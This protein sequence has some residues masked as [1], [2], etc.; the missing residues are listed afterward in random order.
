MRARLSGWTTVLILLGASSAWAGN[1]R[2]LQLGTLPVT[3]QGLRPTVRVGINGRRATFLLDSGAFYSTISAD[4]AARYRLALHAIPGDEVYLTGAG[5]GMTRPRLTTVK[6]FSYLSAPLHHVQF[7]VTPQNFWGRLAGSLGQNLLRVSDVEYDLAD[8]VVRF[9]RPVGC[10]GQPLAYWAE[11]TPYSVVKLRYLGVA[12]S[13]LLAHA[14]VNG[15]RITVLLDTGSPRSILSLQAARRA[16]ITRHSPG[17]KPLETSLGLGGLHFQVWSAPVAEFQIGGE[18]I[19]HTHL[20]IGNI[21]PRGPAGQIRSNRHVDM[22]LGADFF[23]SQRLYVAYSQHR[24]YFTYNGGPLFNLNLPQYGRAAAQSVAAAARPLGAADLMRRGMALA[25]LREFHRAIADLSRACTLA[26]HDARD[27]YERGEVYLAQQRYRAALADFDAA[28]HLAP[29]DVAAH[30]AR[31]ELR[32]GQPDAAAHRAQID[33]DLAAVA[34]QAAH[35]AALQLELGIL[36]GEAGRYRAGLAQINRWLATH[37]PRSEQATGLNARCWLRALSDR[38]LHRALADCNEALNLSAEDTTGDGPELPYLRP[39]LPGSDPAVRD[40][41]AL[42]YLRLGRNH[43]AI[44]DYD[45][46]LASTPD[47]PTSL[48]GRGLAELRLGERRRG[49]ADLAAAK[50]HYARIGAVFRHFGLVPAS[51]AGTLKKTTIG[52]HTS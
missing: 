25:A 38:A 37:R 26:P 19:E 20:L 41:R 36:Y 2:L 5:G 47:T 7:L 52:G 32:L 51:P 11:K 45:A 15:K 18:R 17:V 16:G 8:G 1:C 48:Y 10:A 30:L 6:T 22:L 24:I 4:T 40:S 27:R 31:A 50:H 12:H 44:R 46:V 14:A 28:L 13:Q 33:A 9:I 23:L 43:R 35:D 49:A 42:V 3:L 29:G 34:R 21:D 39:T